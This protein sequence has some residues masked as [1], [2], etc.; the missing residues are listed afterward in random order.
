MGSKRAKP[1][2]KKSRMV[3]TRGWEQRKWEDIG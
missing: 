1:A 3:A 2:E